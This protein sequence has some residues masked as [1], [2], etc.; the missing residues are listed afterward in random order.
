MV[1]MLLV[2]GGLVLLF[3]LLVRV[4]PDNLLLP[5]YCLFTTAGVGFALWEQRRIGARR[6]AL[7]RELERER[8]R[9]PEGGLPWG[10]QDKEG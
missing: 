5:L 3:Y 10:K 7:E 6:G 2:L 8:L 9:G 1:R 4:V